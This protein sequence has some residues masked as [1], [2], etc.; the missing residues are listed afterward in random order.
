MKTSFKLAAVIV[1][2]GLVNPVQGKTNYRKWLEEEAVWIVSQK[3]KDAF[4]V[5]Q[6]DAERDAFIEKFWQERDPT[7]STPRNEYKEEHYRRYEY[8]LKKFQEGMPGWKSDRGRIYI[9]HGPP[10][11]EYFHTSDSRLSQRSTD[12]HGRTPNTIV[13]T[14]RGNPNGKYY[15]GELN[16]VFQPSAGLS[17]QSFVMGESGTAQEKADELARLFGPAVDQTWLEADVRYRLIA[18]GPPAIVNTRGVDI[19][20]A[21]LGENA[22]YLED[23]LRSPGEILEEKKT[24]AR[25]LE[26]ART[27]LRDA[28]SARLSFGSMP[29]GLFSRSFF[30]SER[31]LTVFVEL[32]LPGSELTT[33]LQGARGDPT[34]VDVYCALVDNSGT[35]VDEFIDSVD[36][37]SPLG[38]SGKGKLYYQNSFRAPPGRYVLKAAARS[39]DQRLGYEERPVDLDPRAGA[40]LRL[41]ELLLT[42]R[43][44]PATADSSDSSSGSVVVGDA[45]LAPSPARR[46]TP[47]DSLFVYSQVFVPGDTENPPL[48]VG[49]TFLADNS[50]YRRL[51]PRRIQNLTSPAAGVLNFATA[52]PLQEFA[53]GK[54]TVQVQV[55]DHEARKFSI[56]RAS[57]EV[58]SLPAP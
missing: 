42:N 37:S 50:V 53:P 54:Y 43:A 8:A 24:R 4:S 27:Q 45:R 33:V 20:T 49:V 48:S 22:R 21:G 3:E 25:A 38:A 12:Q 39:G 51:E 32:E 5:L 36:V 15:R 44:Q 7:P 10:A 47:S 56:Q 9:L 23:L 1:L 34:R 28:V 17:R 13:W 58:E 31:S 40:T 19:P 16:L 57:F 29:L 52:V 35:L 11:H 55:I 41:S 30:Q 14:Y 6:S 2:S 46:F 26:A 18:A